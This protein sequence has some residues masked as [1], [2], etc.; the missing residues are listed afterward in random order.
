MAVMNG[1][2]PTLARRYFASTLDIITVIIITVFIVKVLDGYSIETGPIWYLVFIP[3]VFYEPVLTS[4][5][6]TL[7]QAVFG[8]RIRD[9]N[10]GNKITL[11]KAYARIV[12][13][14]LLGII[15]LLTIPHDEK[16]RAIHDKAISTVALNN[17][18][19]KHKI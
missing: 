8:F 4:Q 13:K 5:F 6:M 18:R 3:A 14:F 16:R 1:V 7:G 2:Y 15:S 19:L 11:L 9:I 17:D 10:T 12:I